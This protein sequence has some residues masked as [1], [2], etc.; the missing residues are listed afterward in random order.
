MDIH[1]LVNEVKQAQED[2]DKI[3]AT[4]RKIEEQIIK[5]EAPLVLAF[6]KE[7]FP[8][9]KKIDIHGTKAVLIYAFDS[10]GKT[11]ISPEV[12][13]KE[14]GEV[15]YKVY[16]EEAYRSFNPM[17]IIKDGYNIIPLEKFLYTVPFHEIFTFYKE[18]AEI[19]YEEA[20]SV[21]EANKYRKIFNEKM[22]KNL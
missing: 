4:Q 7:I 6:A 3:K 5:E 17:A 16:D 2:F 8:F 14:N 9:S 18:R 11:L 13:L 22:K 19:L 1:E 21:I 20:E 10:N 12:F 15:V